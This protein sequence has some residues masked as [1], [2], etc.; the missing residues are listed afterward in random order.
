MTYLHSGWGVQFLDYDND[1]TKDLLAGRGHVMDTVEQNFPQLSYREPLLLAKNTSSSFVDVSATAGSVFSQAWSAR[2]LAIGDIDNDGRVDAVVTTNDGPAHVLHNDTSTQ[3]HWLTLK[4][5]GHES[6]R[7]AIGAE[8]TIVTP[9]G[10][11]LATVTTAGSYLSSSDKRV[12]FG[13]GNNATVKR[14]DIRW[15]SGIRQTLTNVP[16]DRIVEIAEPLSRERE[17]H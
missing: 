8:I 5:I 17:S 4:L 1:G 16:G 10:Q 2:G 14:I 3:N 9:D 12:H 7:D 13:L 11:Q 6:N 15:P